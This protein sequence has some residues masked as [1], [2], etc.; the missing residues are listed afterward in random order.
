MLIVDEGGKIINSPHTTTLPQHVVD[1][2]AR[3]CSAHVARIR[4]CH[5]KG[6]MSVVTGAQGHVSLASPWVWDSTGVLQG[7]EHTEFTDL[8]ILGGSQP[9]GG[10]GDAHHRIK[11]PPACSHNAIAPVLSPR[12]SRWPI[13]WPCNLVASAD[14]ILVPSECRKTFWPMSFHRRAPDL[15]SAPPDSSGS[16]LN[17]RR[18]SRVLRARS[19]LA[20]RWTC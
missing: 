20:D 7:R 8:R 16:D 13:L 5:P 15:C 12:S 6:A 9:G 1:Q 19:A 2:S 11:L 3:R 10:G 17:D 14:V 18:Q 4:R